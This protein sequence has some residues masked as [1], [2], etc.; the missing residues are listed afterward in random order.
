MIR[1]ELAAISRI[2]RDLQG[3]EGVMVA[4]DGAIWAADGR[5]A[6]MRIAADGSREERIGNLGG[7]PNGICLDAEGRII[8]TGSEGA[9]C[10]FGGPSLV[11]MAL[12]R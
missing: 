7:Q 11:L 3:C 9:G 4:R 5:G 12:V 6:C 1:I 8:A 2:G 10:G